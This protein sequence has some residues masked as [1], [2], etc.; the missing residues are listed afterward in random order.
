MEATAEVDVDDFIEVI[1]FY[2][3]AMIVEGYSGVVYQDVEGAEG[4]D[5]FRNEGGGEGRRSV[6]KDG[7]T[8]QSAEREAFFDDFI[9]ERFGGWRDV[10]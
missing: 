8:I 1:I 9:D 5:Y 2:G 4:G 7:A 3:G 6:G 10:S